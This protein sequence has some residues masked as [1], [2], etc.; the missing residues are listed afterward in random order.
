MCPL[1][2]VSEAAGEMGKFRAVVGAF[3][4]AWTERA[5][6]VLDIG[7]RSGG[8][9][10]AL[11]G[12]VARY[13]AVDLAAPADVIARCDLDLPFRSGAF[14]TVVALDVL[15][16]T[17]DIHRSFAELCRVSRRSVVIS[18]PNLFDFRCRLRVLLGKHPN[19]KYGL[20]PEPPP[21]RHRW[22]FG[23]SEAREFLHRG[24][25]KLGFQVTEECC[26]AGARTIRLLGRSAIRRRPDLF[27]QTYLCL[28]R[29]TAG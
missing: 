11:P 3:P 9:K 24:A 10:R 5:A 19:R 13:C 26:L 16:H 18:L 2:V 14:A 4:A 22:L 23:F 15:E 7:S 28:L 20:P 29:R 1:R 8:L 25:P 12:S 6:S 21:D 17:D 27:G